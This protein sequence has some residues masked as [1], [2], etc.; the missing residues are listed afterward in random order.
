MQKIGAVLLVVLLT[1]AA[2]GGNRSGSDRWPSGRT[3]LSTSV[4]ENGQDRPPVSGTRIELR[5]ADGRLM[6][7]GGCNHMDADGHL[8]GNRLVLGELATTGMGCEQA[9]MAQDRWL[10]E[11]LRGQPTW[12]LS[13]DDLVLTNG[14]TQ[15][16]LTDR[17]VAD[18]DRA[19]TGTRWVVDSIISRDTVSSVPS[20]V[21]AYLQL[22]SAGGFQGSTG[23]AQIAGSATV[24]ADRITFVMPTGPSPR[25]T[26]PAA[27][28]E[29]AVLG[30]LR[31]EAVYQIEATR[32]TLTGANGAGLGLRARA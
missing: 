31:G 22:D 23:C 16:R 3:F 25:C 24:R 17:R 12:E 10:G 20:G 9:L 6:A 18:P 1:T 13:G 19:L 30:V 26:G 11:F 32:L 5:F 27:T 14:G 8:D 28:L 2:C 21:E 4:T 29:S 15:I 7:R